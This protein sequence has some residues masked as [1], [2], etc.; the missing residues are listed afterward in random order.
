[1]E[2]SI[3]LDDFGTGYSSLTYLKTLPITT[4]KLDKTFIDDIVSSEVSLTIVK[5]VI[6]IAKS[7]GLKII[8]EGVETKEQLNILSTLGCDYIQ[9]F[10]F[11]KPIP[12]EEIAT[13]FAKDNV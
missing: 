11:S 7:T 10:Y 9:G 4:L 1:M 5:S 2:I 6:Q 3:A 12:E 8:V 13:L